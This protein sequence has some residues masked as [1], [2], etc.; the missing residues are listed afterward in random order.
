[1]IKDSGR[2]LTPVE[3][4]GRNLMRIVDTLPA[5]YAVGVVVALLT[6][7]NKRLGDLV[8]GSLVVRESS[9]SELKPSWNKVPGPAVQPQSMLGADRLS[10]EECMLID[11]FLN[12]R[13]DLDFDVRYRMADE[14]FRRFRSKLTLPERNDLSVEKI[15]ESLAN[16]RRATRNYS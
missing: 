11:S 2:P 3:S 10:A 12:R 5:F 6:K 14:I 13:F 4:I 9:F 7:E 1:V 8:V 16:E 15:L